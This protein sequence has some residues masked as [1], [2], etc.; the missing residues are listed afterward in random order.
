MAAFRQATLRPLWL[1]PAK[2][3]PTVTVNQGLQYPSLQPVIFESRF[4]TFT[5]FWLPHHNGLHADCRAF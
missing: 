3:G 2:T 4:S 5:F 1:D